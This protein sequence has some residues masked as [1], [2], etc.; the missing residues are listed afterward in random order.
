MQFY[1]SITKQLEPFTHNINEP[2]KW[3]VCGPTV[4]DFSHLGHARTYI[5][6]DVIRRVLIK[7]GYD[8]TYVMNITNI[9][10]KI[11]NRVKERS[12]SD[13]MD[14][15]VYDEFIGE[16][17]NLF[18]KDMDNLR[19]IRPTIVTRVTEYIDKMVKYC[20]KIVDNG[21]GYTVNESVYID[22][23]KMLMD[24]FEIDIFNQM[25][26]EDYTENDY[27]S[28]KKHKHDFALLK[29]SKREDI[30]YE[31][32]FGLVLPGWHLECS[33]MLTN[34]LGDKIDIHAGGIDLAH[35]HHCNEI[36]Q[37]KA[38]NNDNTNPIKL[39]LHTG[40]LHINGAKMSKSLKNFITINEYLEKYG[41][42]RQMR[43]LFLIHNWNDP[44]EFNQDTLNETKIT[45]KKII[46][47]YNN[48]QHI[49]KTHNK[50]N[51][52]YTDFDK[53]FNKNI[54]T[55]KQLIN[56]SINNNI[57]TKNIIKQLMQNIKTTNVYL[58]LLND[59]NNVL[60]N[61]MFN[62][63]NDTLEMFG[64]EFKN[65][66]LLNNNETSKFI[67]LIVDFRQKTRNILLSK[68]EPHKLKS[69]LYSL[70]DDIRDIKMK[71]LGVTIEDQKGE[72]KWN[73]L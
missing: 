73:Y 10:D 58:Q 54:Q 11:I 53:E 68:N 23:Q 7:K 15:K 62:H 39:F 56:F 14:S 69:D 5:G 36:I 41:T 25:H 16:M 9:D 30:G 48:I 3:Y 33:A 1:N 61:E 20:E 43:L 65:K 19:V 26:E 49:N 50:I 60:V 52:K 2:I 70:I 42:S 35:P 22:S 12:N 6:F 29:K 27:V 31:T 18:W 51:I 21:Y 28:E 72:T 24:G 8:V 13:R 67:D 57:D 40:H 4:Y 45:E 64:L 55:S 38:Y 71:E 66:D 46:D 32:D 59:F 37:M 44:M 47:F 63:I 34:V 17:E